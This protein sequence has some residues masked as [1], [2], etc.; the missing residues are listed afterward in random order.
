MTTL[1]WLAV[2]IFSALYVRSDTDWRAIP[3]LLLFMATLAFWMLPVLPEPLPISAT[4]E[5]PWHLDSPYLF[6]T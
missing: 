5:V 3:A 6:L 2:L 1:F 4:I